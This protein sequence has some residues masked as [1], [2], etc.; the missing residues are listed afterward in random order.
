[1]FTFGMSAGIVVATARILDILVKMARPQDWQDIQ[2]LKT[3]EKDTKKKKAQ[4]AAKAL[5]QY[6]SANL[7]RP[8]GGLRDGR[9]PRNP[10]GVGI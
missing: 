2:G 5:T 1:V 4:I 7:Y 9:S 8:K 6:P 10:L 3:G